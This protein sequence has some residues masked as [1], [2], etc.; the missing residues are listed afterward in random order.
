MLLGPS[1]E[2]VGT[3]MNNFGLEKYLASYWGK[4]FRTKVGD[5]YI[6]ERMLKSGSIFGGE[7]SGHI[8][9]KIT[10]QLGMVF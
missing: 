7:P 5:R 10:Q 1:N 2:V 4:L 6:V 9:L 8:I 3:V